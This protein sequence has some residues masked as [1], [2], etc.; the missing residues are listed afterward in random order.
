MF[1][2]TGE[3]LDV[4]IFG[5]EREAVSSH[6][7]KRPTCTENVIRREYDS[8]ACD[9]LPVTFFIKLCRL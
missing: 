7:M 9:N 5:V 1:V 6:L 8:Q 2:A 3:V 4:T